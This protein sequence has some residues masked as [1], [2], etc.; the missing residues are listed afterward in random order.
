[1]NDS[2]LKIEESFDEGKKEI[3]L[4]SIIKTEI[5]DGLCPKLATVRLMIEICSEKVNEPLLQKSSKLLEEILN[6]LRAISRG[7]NPSLETPTDLEA[8]LEDWLNLYQSRRPFEFKIKVEPNVLE[9]VNVS[10]RNHIWRICQELAYNALKHSFHTFLE[11][12]IQRFGNSVALFYHNNGIEQNN[13][14][15]LSQKEALWTVKYR[16]EQMNGQLTLK[17]KDGILSIGIF[18]PIQAFEN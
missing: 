1:M 10:T 17:V 9:F 7:L 16:V 3:S 8:A 11:L 14:L 6:D 15:A 2:L 18:L 13:K 4:G 12:R 5:H